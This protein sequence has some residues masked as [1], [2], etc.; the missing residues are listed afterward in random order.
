MIG[1]NSQEPPFDD[2]LVRQAFSYAFDRQ[3][4]ISGLF[5]NN[6]LPALGPLPPGMPGYTGRITGYGYN[7]ELARSLLAQAGYPDPADFPP[8][9]YTTSGYGSVGSYVTALITMWQ[10]TLG[11]TIE[12]VLVEPFNFLN[13]LYAGNTGNLY[14]HG[15]C[16]DYPDPE[17][18]LD[19]LFHSGAQQNLG[20][21]SN[22][23][24]DALLDQ[25][26]IE[27]DIT[28]RL[29]LYAEIEQL[30][31]NDAPAIFTTHSLSAELVA[32]R[33]QNYVLSP[34]GVAQWHTISLPP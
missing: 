29:A 6:V 14:A 20:G 10:E 7:P 11:V 26:R 21:Y 9:T 24:I 15:W 4:L 31:I 28:T 1:F 30:L 25:A 33:L 18:F 23:E 32:P 22:P 8:I 13:E 2:P 34:I 27:P 17:N 16:A 3:R 19:V 12:P 5:K